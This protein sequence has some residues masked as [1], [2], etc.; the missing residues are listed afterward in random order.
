MNQ[1]GGTACFA[2]LAAIGCILAP[3]VARAQNVYRINCGGPDFLD[4]QGNMWQSDNGSG[5]FNVGR[6]L[7]SPVSDTIDILG[8]DLD[9]LYR[10]ERYDGQ[11]A[12]NM[13]YTLPV[14]PGY[15]LVKL[16]FAEVYWTKPNRR[17]FDVLIEGDPR[18]VNY[19]I[20]D[21][22]G[23]YTADVRQF[24]VVV[25]D[26]D[27]QIEFAPSATPLDNAKISAIEID[28]I[29]AA[30]IITRVSPK[31]FA[32]P[33]SS[34]C[35]SP[36]NRLTLTAD[37]PDTDLAT[38]T[39]SV[40]S[41]PKRGTIAFVGEIDVGNQVQVCYMPAAGQKKSDSFTL[42]VS[43]NDPN[44]GSSDVTV[45]VTLTDS[46]PPVLTCPA[47]VTIF[48]DDSS[49]PST[50]GRATAV[51][52][53]DSTPTITFADEVETR[54]CPEAVRIKRTWTA[55]DDS[56]NKSTCIQTIKVFAGDQDADGVIDC[57]DDCPLDP[58]KSSPGTCGCGKSD[59]D[60]NGDGKP[61]CTPT[62]PENTGSGTGGSGV[63]DGSTPDPA[64]QDCCGGG[65]PALLPFMMMGCRRRRRR[66]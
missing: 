4:P 11:S 56:G 20:I 39:W 14:T 53:F 49:E 8:T 10:T 9:T 59:E 19:D 27:L 58:F 45:I 6:T 1:R 50:T 37:D 33:Y 34:D 3:G 62:T 24:V 17:K 29:T 13:T 44:G 43:D 32:V 40:R 61:D 64:T 60:M 46:I 22:I 35:N 2:A 41:A 7:P 38:L 16:H 30:P 51:D 36:V 52:E 18:L 23:P 12:P 5:Y 31:D 28:E 48:A 66:R 25:A 55:T 63:D 21:G 54:A 47:N 26:N 65:A 57:E 15:Y 42:R